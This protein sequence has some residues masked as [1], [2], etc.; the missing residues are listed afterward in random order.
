MES[1]IDKGGKTYFYVGGKVCLRAVEKEDY[2]EHM[3]RWANDPEFNKYLS[4][5]IR[6]TSVAMMN[7]L[8]EDLRKKDNA[9]FAIVDGATD[10]VIGIIG[11]HHISCQIRSAEYTI[12]IGE[13]EF[14]GSGAGSEATDYILQYA[15]DTLNLN[16]VWLGVAEPNVKAAR[17]YEKKGFVHEGKSRDEI[18]REGRYFDSIRM[19]IL[20]REYDKRRNNL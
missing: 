17:F 15:F 7:E 5:G 13:K 18:Y 4:H 14:W 19:S 11:L 12:H 20:R 8:Y 3:Y 2:T 16:K 1:I 9:V 6:P 10:T